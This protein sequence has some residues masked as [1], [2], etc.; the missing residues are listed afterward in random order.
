ME[1]GCK[2]DG[3]ECRGSIS[4]FTLPFS[5]ST[6]LSKRSAYIFFFCFFGTD[7][8]GL[9][10]DLQEIQKAYKEGRHVNIPNFV[11]GAQ[12]LAMHLQVFPF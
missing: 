6:S 3:K 10:Y 1:C 9:L 4:R 7:Y 12:D 8:K 11:A 2:T 5:V